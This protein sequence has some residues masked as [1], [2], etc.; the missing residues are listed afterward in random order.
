M[1][2]SPERKQELKQQ[3]HFHQEVSRIL[4]D[5]KFSS[6]LDEAADNPQARQSF[7]NDAAAHLKQR[8]VDIPGMGQG[9]TVE[10]HSSLFCIKICFFSWCY[11][12]CPF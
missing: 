5:P 1:P 3:A 4:N 12:W 2:L 7:V 8:G 11:N 6:A 10:A 9:W